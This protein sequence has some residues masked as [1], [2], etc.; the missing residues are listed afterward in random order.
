M[1][2]PTTCGSSPHT[3]RMRTPPKLQ[4]TFSAKTVYCIAATLVTSCLLNV[5][6]FLSQCN[7]LERFV[8][9]SVNYEA[10]FLPLSLRTVQLTIEDSVHYALY[11]DEDWASLIPRHGFIRL[12]VDGQ[13]HE[14]FAVSMYH[15]LHCLNGFRRLTVAAIGNNQTQHNIDHAIH[16]LSYLRQTILCHADTALEPARPADTVKGGKTQAVYGEGTVHRCRD[17]TQVREW[18]EHNYLEWKDDDGTYEASEG[19]KHADN[20]VNPGGS[21]N[22]VDTHP[23]E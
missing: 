7:M 20:T 6:G 9:E 16:C 12:P 22:R 17:W 18:V 3:A 1:L 21:N 19:H 5:L 15:Q 10:N 8:G 23:S 4:Y 11:S 13:D 2:S 14:Y